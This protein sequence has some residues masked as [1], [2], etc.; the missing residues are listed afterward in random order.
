M[1][2][3]PLLVGVIDLKSGRAVHAVGGH[4]AAYRPLGSVFPDTVGTSD[5][6]SV[7]R[8]LLDRGAEALYVADLD[9]LAGSPPNTAAIAAI[10]SC[11][12]AV[13]LDAG[14]QP[15]AVPAG[16]HRIA[17]ME[18]TAPFK[19]TPLPVFGLDLHAGLL[20]SGWGNDPVTVAKWAVVQGYEAIVL[21]DTA[22]VGGDRL[23]IV[24]V[25][26]AITAAVDVPLLAGGGVRTASDLSALSMC[27]GV[28]IGSALYRNELTKHRD[29]A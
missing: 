15:F 12:V 28:L 23:T 4:R 11:G 7:A 20:A 29:S 14:V 1:K 19:P 10:A 27:D 13:W 22:A 25:C 6:E 21:V 18:A 26:A 17:A 3:D 2:G 24:D 5:P 16:V 8:L 9:A